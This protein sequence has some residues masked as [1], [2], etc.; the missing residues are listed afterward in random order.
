MERLDEP[1][2]PRARPE[3]ARWEIAVVVAVV[4]AGWRALLGW[5]W[6]VAQTTFDWVAFGLV[7]MLGVGW[8]ARRGRGIAG[9]VA[10]TVPVILLSGWRLAASGV[11]GWPVGLASLIFSLCL[12]CMMTAVLGAWLR[13]A[14]ARRH[15]GPR[16]DVGA[17]P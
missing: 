14:G 17:R 4:L 16:R 12:T 15:A 1:T 7:A 5:D 2:T 3:A 11:T 6:A 13:R 8:L 10:V 9:T